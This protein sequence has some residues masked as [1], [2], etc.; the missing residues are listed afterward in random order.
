M[1]VVSKVVLD[2]IPPFFL[3]SLRLGLSIPLLGLLAWRRGGLR[4]DWDHWRP[5]LLAGAVGYGL[6]L[7][8][9]FVGTRLSTAANGALVTSASPA[10]I[11][12][13]AAILLRERITPPRLLALLLATAGVLVVIDPRTASLSRASLWGNLALLGA[14][15]TWGLHSVLVR[16]AT[17][18]AKRA[19]LAFTAM[20][21]LGGLPISL[22]GAAVEL[23]A[24]G[25]GA[26]TPGVVWGVL[27]LGLVST[28]G[29]AYLWN[30]SFELLDAG[31][32]SLFFFAQP[33]VGAFLGWWLL[34][35]SLTPGFFWGGAL[36]A[37]GVALGS[38][39]A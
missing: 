35:E 4:F 18:D 23:R 25:L 14:A 31:V 7:G 12:L 20:A 6:S 5:A 8:L 22:P 19:T 17:R 13:F 29:A 10:F 27:Y 37:A 11:V 39:A 30:K 26:V 36:I 28:A 24:L 3:L 16:R 1:Y 33:V 2:V 38:R 21:L 32:A 15:L 9:Q 34:G